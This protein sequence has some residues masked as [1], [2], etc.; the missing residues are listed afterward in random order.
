MKFQRGVWKQKQIVLCLETTWRT[1]T[2]KRQGWS[3]PVRKDQA[4]V[5]QDMLVLAQ[6][7]HDGKKKNKPHRIPPWLLNGNCILLF[8]FFSCFESRCLGF[9]QTPC[10]VCC[11][12][13]LLFC[14]PVKSWR[15]WHWAFSSVLCL[16]IHSSSLHINVQQQ[17]I[18]KKTN[19]SII[20]S[21]KEPKHSNLSFTKQEGFDFKYHWGDNCLC[22]EFHN[23]AR[24]AI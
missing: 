21:L 11:T 22:Y 17:Q 19:P 24:V 1:A 18:E 3:I 8:S 23:G 6:T 10:T 9:R 20:L 2:A 16:S 12:H 13:L 15:N 7:Q 4:L 5:P 14:Q